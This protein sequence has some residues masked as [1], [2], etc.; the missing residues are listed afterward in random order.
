MGGN[1]VKREL[2]IESREDQIDAAALYQNIVKIFL[3]LA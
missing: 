1:C 3:T 2:G